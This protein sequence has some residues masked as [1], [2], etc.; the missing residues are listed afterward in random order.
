MTA[1]LTARDMPMKNQID[2]DPPDFIVSPYQKMICRMTNTT[3]TTA[4]QNTGA[5]EDRDFLFVRN[6]RQPI[7]EIRQLRIRFGLGEEAHDDGDDHTDQPAPECPKHV[8]RL[9]LRLR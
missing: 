2:N 1:P 9:I 4:P 7:D 5:V 6:R 8:L 3:A